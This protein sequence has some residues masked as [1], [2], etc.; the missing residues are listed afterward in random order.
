M[1]SGVTGRIHDCMLE[2]KMFVYSDPSPS[3]NHLSTAV[4]NQSGR[5]L[6]PRP[7]AFD[8]GSH[9]RAFNNAVIRRP[10]DPNLKSGKFSVTSH[11]AT[12][13]SVPSLAVPF[14]PLG[15][16]QGDYGNTTTRRQQWRS[17][18]ALTDRPN[19]GNRNRRSTLGYLGRRVST[20]HAT[21]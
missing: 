15:A 9:F 18:L 7:P 6:D 13:A 17:E 8:E 21:S 20:W 12:G 16:P 19:I 11:H 4:T 1:P 5:M 3:R 14:H 2:S 10:T